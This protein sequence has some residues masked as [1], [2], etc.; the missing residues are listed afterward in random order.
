MFTISGNEGLL[1]LNEEGE[2]K[3]SIKG[4]MKQTPENYIYFMQNKNENQKT[5]QFILQTQDQ[6]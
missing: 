3:Q 5:H 4:I 2:I 6:H 1:Y